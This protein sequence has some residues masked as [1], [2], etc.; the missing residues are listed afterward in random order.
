MGPLLLTGRSALVTGGTRGIGEAIARRL[1]KEGAS[2][3]VT[4]TRLDGI[5]PPGCS[6]RAI[7]FEDTAA[8]EAFAQEA[9]EM[10][11]DILIN[12]AGINVISPFEE[13]DP[14]DFDRIHRVNVRAP[15]LLCRALIPR[16]RERGWGR[17]VNLSSIFGKVSR[18]HRA[19]YS[20]S[21]F[22]LDGMT[23]AL[24]A[25][26]AADGILANCVAPGF[27]DTDL[28]R[29]ILG[30]QGIA[31]L[32]ARIPIKR[33]GTVEEIAAFVV[34]LAGPENTYISGQNIAIDGGFTRV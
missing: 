14:K 34:W 26:V 24:A 18:E 7:D 25:E 21:K 30:E 17:I 12:N 31:A 10:G 5:P 19:A 2:V 20:A 16:M 15:F 13:V 8:T 4:G 3:L 28:T 29:R 27:I 1:V 9:A 11:F 23:A 22:G 33:L 6:Y 32:M